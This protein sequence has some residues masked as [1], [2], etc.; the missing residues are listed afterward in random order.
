MAF[1]LPT[2]IQGVYTII[3]KTDSNN[4]VDAV[5]SANNVLSSNALVV[6]LRNR[7][8]LEVVT[9]TGPPSVTANTAIDVSWTVSNL[10][11]AATPVG[12]SQWSDSVYLSLDNQFDSGDFLLGSSPNGS[13]LATGQSYTSIGHYHLPQ[14][15][16][17]NAYLIFVPDSG[18]AV[19]Q[20]PHASPN[21]YVTPIAIDATP[22]PPPDLVVS[23]VVVPSQAF[24]GTPIT[25]RYVVSNL[26]T[27]PTT[28][29]SWSD[30]IW[31]T[32]T[33]G[34]PD[35]NGGDILLGYAGHSGDLLVGG[36]YNGS[37]TVTLPSGLT[38]NFYV[39]VWTNP[40]G[41]IYQ[42]HLSA[43]VNPDAPNDL[44][45]DNFKASS[46]IGIAL[47][48]TAD[49]VVTNVTAPATA[50]GGTDVTL[51]WT[52][53]NQG[54]VPTNVDRWVDSVYISTT[55]T[56]NAP[57]AI[58]TRVFA[59]PN[60]GTLLPNQSYTQTATFTLPPSAQGSFFIVQTNENPNILDNLVDNFPPS[61][62]RGDHRA[63]GTGLGL[64]GDRPQQRPAQPADPGPAAT[65]PDWT[66]RLRAADGVRGTEHA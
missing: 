5:S 48:P 33:K 52:V 66:E 17:G 35:P 55:P 44:H 58:V 64:L 43:N 47:Q 2:K 61:P 13:A 24:D 18:N 10:G 53:E 34:R 15:I 25:V 60:F 62:G 27:G 16:S 40:N 7:P 65:D 22:V 31:L 26:G 8:D 4:S 23:N 41:S 49:L 42:T 51:S 6:T 54:A 63:G 21:Y 14:A 38:G 56:I 32:K 59:A 28:A 3:V 29:G 50:L 1:N 45:G 37:A 30:A 12:G 46:P 11:V 39:T 57:G 20:G 19:D 36:N 9:A